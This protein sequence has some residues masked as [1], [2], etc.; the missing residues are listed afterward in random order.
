ML[1]ARVDS[2]HK[3]LQREAAPMAKTLNI[4]RAL[5]IRVTTDAYVRSLSI[6]D[7]VLTPLTPIVY[8]NNWLSSC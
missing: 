2:V 4:K 6:L 3:L 7:F 5:L 1:V 8:A